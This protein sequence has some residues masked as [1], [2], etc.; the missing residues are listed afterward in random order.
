MRERIELAASFQPG[1]LNDAAR[2]VDVCY[3]TGAPV[4]RVDPA[5]GETYT[6]RLDP[7]GW[8]LRS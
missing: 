4:Q 2:I 1:T 8:I 7:A 5:T 6:L 3:F